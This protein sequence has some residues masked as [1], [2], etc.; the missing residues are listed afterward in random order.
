MKQNTVN[1]TSDKWLTTEQLAK[2]LEVSVRT[3]R[4]WIAVKRVTP[5]KLSERNYR[6]HLAT[7]KAELLK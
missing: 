3:I 1:K 6:F 4:R 7:V 5:I 2:E